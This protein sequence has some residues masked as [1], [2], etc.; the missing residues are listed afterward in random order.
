[1]KNGHLQNSKLIHILKKHDRVIVFY[2]LL[3]ELEAIKNITNRDDFPNDIRIAEWNGQKHEP[4]L[5]TKRWLYL[6]QYNAGAEGWNC[7]STNAM[8]L[9]SLNYSYKI[10]EQAF[11]RIDRVNNTYHDLYYYQ[12]VSKSPMD[13]AILQA[14]NHKR[15]FNE[16]IFV[17]T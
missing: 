15:K 11:G 10:M 1:M 9:Y 5:D 3:C 14:I 4:I 12:F 13:K 16:T 8:V 7:T 2:N 6:V 17:R